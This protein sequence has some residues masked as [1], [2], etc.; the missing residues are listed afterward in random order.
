MMGIIDYGSTIEYGNGAKK[1]SLTV[2]SQDKDEFYAVLY[3]LDGGPIDITVS[4]LGADKNSDPEHEYFMCLDSYFDEELSILVE[5]LNQA[6]K[7][8]IDRYACEVEDIAYTIAQSLIIYDEAALEIIKGFSLASWSMQAQGLLALCK[9]VHYG[10]PG[11][12]IIRKA[13]KDIDLHISFAQ[14]E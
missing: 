11:D 4:V 5:E 8:L 13:I 9:L 7:S 10:K 14:G 6:D 1:G 3:E 2:K 12:G